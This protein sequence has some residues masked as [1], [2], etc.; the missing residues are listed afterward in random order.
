M[1][2]L[3]PGQA[4]APEGPA[5]LTMMYVL[6]HGF[7]RD[8]RDFTLAAEATPLSDADCW[9][10]IADRWDLFA[11]L[12]H[13]HHTKED[14]VLWPL[15]HDRA[16]DADDTE[17]L[18]VLDEME[19]EHALI[20]PLLDRV[21]AAVRDMTV[22]PDAATRDDLVSG[23][24]ATTQAL[25]AHL[26]HEERDAIAALQRLVGGKEWEEIERT[27]LRGGLTRKALVAMLPWAVEGLPAPFVSALL[28]DS[29]LPFRVMLRLGRPRF[30]RLQKA[31][32]AHVPSGTAA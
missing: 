24:R 28:A 29:G 9:R 8:L 21:W 1:S 16:V 7:R 10:G 14:E 6:H 12:L 23:L 30:S 2:T 18:R 5:D 19:A 11:E 22:E 31:A 27:R 3:L 20:D 15:L 32:F 13:D 4:A 26:G 17:A 25:D